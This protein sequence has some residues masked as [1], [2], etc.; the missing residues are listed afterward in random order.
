MIATRTPDRDPHVSPE[1][2]AAAMRR[3]L[4]ARRFFRKPAEAPLHI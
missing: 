2:L 3:G 4:E 1:E